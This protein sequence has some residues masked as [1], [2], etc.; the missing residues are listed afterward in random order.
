MSR[1]QQDA[2]AIGKPRQRAN[3]TSFASFGWR[4]PKSD[5]PTPSPINVP[6]AA[7]QPLSLD[8]LIEVLKPPAV[9]SLAHARALAGILTTASPLPRCATINEI[10]SSLCDVNGPLSF[11]A[12]GFDILSS[13][14]ENPEAVVVE[15]AD[16]LSFFSLFLGSDVPWAID[17]WEPRFKALRA[18]TKY[19]ADIVGIE[20]ALIDVIKR[21]I[22]GAFDGLLR[23]G[24]DLDRMERTERERSVD[25]LVKFLFDILNKPENI[26]RLPEDTILVMIRFY[27]ALVERSI[28]DLE[29]PRTQDKFSASSDSLASISQSKPGL[30]RRNPSSLS[31]TSLTSPTTPTPPAISQNP[32][33]HPAEIA[34][35]IYLD[36]L[37]SQT[38]ALSPPSLEDILVLL[39]RSLAFCASPLPRLTV[40]PHPRKKPSLEDKVLEALASIYA[41][42]YSTTCMGILKRCLHP[43]FLGDDDSEAE[44]TD[45]P[46]RGGDI[47]TSGPLP[48]E[49]PWELLQLGI[50]TSLGAYRMLRCQ[51]RRTLISRLARAY[52]SRE[53][54]IGYSYSGAPSH[55]DVEQDLMEKAWPRDDYVANAGIGLSSAANGWDARRI[56][57][58]LAESVADWVAW[59][60]EGPHAPSVAQLDRETFKESWDRERQRADK[61]LEEAAGL[62][63]DILQEADSRDED[64]PGLDDEEAAVVGGTLYSL[65]KYIPPLRRVRDFMSWITTHA[66]TP[67]TRM[68]LLLS[69]RWI[70]LPMRPLHS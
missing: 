14:W 41:G 43:R 27:A 6:P 5:H 55:I 36:Y 22:E 25:V 48:H 4:R 67:G 39:F 47:E 21:W 18:L 51:V 37:Q 54:S 12:A 44:N 23:R 45:T 60:G 62:L 16:R 35:T 20:T 33:K 52:I 28:V 3:T 10:L 26:A 15:T 50:F 24:A 9:P 7:P 63:K 59:I 29:D 30:H 65:C 2:S 8:E 17:L 38:K 31:A 61:I 49:I 32:Y 13:Y 53:T 68:A 46:Q 34:I 70:I 58:A 66:L 19:G 11:Q 69:F 57:P 1:Q 64:S 56:G 42:P 40:L